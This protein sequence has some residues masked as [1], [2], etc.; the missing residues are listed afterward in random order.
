MFSTWQQG[1]EAHAPVQPSEERGGVAA[2]ESGDAEME[3]KVEQDDDESEDEGVGIVAMRD[4]GLAADALWR[5][6][7]ASAC[8]D[9][10]AIKG[11]LLETLRHAC[12]DFLR[13]RE[14]KATA[15]FLHPAGAGAAGDVQRALSSVNVALGFRSKGSNQECHECL[16]A[17]ASEKQV[18]G[19]KRR[20][21]SGGRRYACAGCRVRGAGAEA[22]MRCAWGCGGMGRRG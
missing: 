6:D 13:H 3:S 22:C 9:Q 11:F 4:D 2:R 12:A 14:Y 10:D 20:A 19:G 7:D 16:R 5:F 17:F 8:G 21:H 15:Y 1:D 18:C